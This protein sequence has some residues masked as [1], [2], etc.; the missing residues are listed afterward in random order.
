MPFCTSDHRCREDVKLNEHL[1]QNLDRNRSRNC[2]I[3][4]LLGHPAAYFA[5]LT[6]VPEPLYGFGHYG[7]TSLD[8]KAG[9]W[10]AAR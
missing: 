1:G 4:W 5:T 2:L 6:H 7:I 8:G 3:E 9:F 10:H